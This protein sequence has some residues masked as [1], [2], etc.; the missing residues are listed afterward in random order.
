MQPGGAISRTTKS[1]LG[2][3]KDKRLHLLAIGI[4]SYISENPLGGCVNDARAIIDWVRA[5]SEDEGCKLSIRGLFDEQATREEVLEAIR[6]HFA[7]AIAGEQ[8]I[9]FFAGHGGQEIAGVEWA[10]VEP[11]GLLETRVCHDSNGK[12]IPDIADKEWRALIGMHTARGVRVTVIFDS[13]HSGHGTR[14]RHT[15]EPSWQRCVQ[16]IA[17]PR[18]KS[19]VASEDR[20]GTGHSGFG[21][22]QGWQERSCL[23]RGCP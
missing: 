7:K 16:R 11:D 5:A 23:G 17:Q 1:R 3:N 19:Q 18:A 8:A 12:S 20:S 6:E 2:E 4:D 22:N 14:R 9:L 13:C 10:D 21:G 15:Q